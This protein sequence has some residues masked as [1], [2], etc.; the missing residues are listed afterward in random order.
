VKKDSSEFSVQSSG[1]CTFPYKCPRGA[2]NH[3]DTLF[4]S[5]QEGD[6]ADLVEFEIDSVRAGFEPTRQFVNHFKNL[7]AGLH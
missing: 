6:Y 7:V 4:D 5:R 3:F 1:K 2:F